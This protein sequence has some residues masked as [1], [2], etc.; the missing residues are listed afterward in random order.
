MTTTIS[1][2]QLAELADL[3]TERLATRAGGEMI[4]AAELARRLGR[5]RDYV[6]DNADSLGVIR[7]GSGARPRLMFK[8][9]LD[10]EQ[11]PKRKRLRAT[12]TGRPRRQR[13]TGTV[14]LLPIRG[15]GGAA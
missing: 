7:I 14:E 15:G 1:P 6:Y 13:T 3:I 2:E 4:D 9:P 12:T 8:W 10:L 11:A 5:S